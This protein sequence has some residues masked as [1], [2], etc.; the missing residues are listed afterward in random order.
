MTRVG[1]SAVALVVLAVVVAGAVTLIRM[2]NGDF[3]GDYPVVGLFSR[4]GEGLQPGSEV[5]FRGVQVGRVSTVALDGTQA[6]HRVAH[7]PVFRVPAD[8]TATIEPVNVFGA[9][10]VTLTTPHDEVAGPY[11]GPGGTLHDAVASDEVGDLLRRGHAAAAA[12]RHRCA[13]ERDV[14]AGGGLRRRRAA[15][16]ATAVGVGGPVGRVPRR[17]LAVAAHRARLVARFTAALA[18]DGPAINGVARHGER[19]AARVQRLG[20]RLSAVH[21]QSD[22]VRQHAGHLLGRLPPRHRHVAEPGRQRG[23]G[24]ADPTERDRPG[25]PRR[26]RVRTQVRQRRRARTPCPTAAATRT[27]TPSSCS[28]TSTRWCAVC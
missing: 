27:S 11:L 4:A 1:R 16:I 10:Q 26:L 28:A 21:R 9:D 17:H 14:R 2:A 7:R 19:G 3:S 24:L 25:R 20:R 23:P 6:R 12:H 18:P 8:T 5:A 13:V 22:P 15:R